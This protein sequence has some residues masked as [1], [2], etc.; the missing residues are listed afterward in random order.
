MLQV[1][2]IE[3]YLRD[4]LSLPV[5][6]VRS[7]GEFAKGHI[8]NATNIPIFSNEE[9]AIVGTA[10]KKIS[11]EKA[12]E[13]GIT[14]VQPKLEG[15]IKDTLIVAKNKT[16]VVHCWRGGMR[17][18]SFA[19]H[20]I[21]NGFTQVYVIQKGYKAFRNHVLNELGKDVPLV[22]VGG[23]TGSAK[24]DLLNHLKNTKGKQVIDLEGL[25]NHRGSA[26]GGIDQASQPTGEQF[27]NKLFWQWKDFDLSQQVF[28]EDESRAIGSLLIPQALYN[29]MR[30]QRLYF[31]DIPREERAKHL[32]K[33]YGKSNVD[34]LKDSI[35]RIST[36]LG[37][38][39]ARNALW[40]LAR[41]EMLEVA[42]IILVYYD[43][44]YSR[45]VARRDPNKVTKI[46]LKTTDLNQNSGELL[47][48]LQAGCSI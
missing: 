9:R 5:V 41:G 4:F 29:N 25:A 11:K 31:L 7:P 46:S 6:D 21:E 20:L 22:I 26:F 45:G 33:G 28:L 18:M 43:K 3:Q 2:N 27:E 47:K 35:S 15:F 37:G 24:T 34:E 8:P 44:Y 42:K 40:H 48:I 10:Y 12:L 38:L 1:I 13:I 36:R 16:V 19:Q 23:Y 39:E 17:S 14:I 32:V 30:S